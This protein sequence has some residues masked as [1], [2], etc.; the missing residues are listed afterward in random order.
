MWRSE[1]GIALVWLAVILGVTAL[2]LV[3][4]IDLLRVWVLWGRLQKAVDAAA[5]AG[6]GS[7]RVREEVDARGTVYAREVLLDPVE[8]KQEAEKVLNANLAELGVVEAGVVE[9]SRVITVQDNWVEV[10]LVVEARRFMPPPWDVITMAR[11]ARA[12]FVAAGP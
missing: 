9:V 8:A 12:E 1:R 4:G 10:Q 7:A 6:A 2:L 11:T 5:L 3:V